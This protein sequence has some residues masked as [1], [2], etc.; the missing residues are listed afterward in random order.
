MCKS[1]VAASS[2]LFEQEFPHG[3]R[4][5]I[6][7]TIEPVKER[8]TSQ[9][10]E[11]AMKIYLQEIGQTTFK[12]EDRIDR[13]SWDLCGRGIIWAGDIKLPDFLPSSK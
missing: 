3:I 13:C 7:S 12:R 11:R 10:S 2:H 6:V 4:E 8:P 9:Q 1:I 5:A